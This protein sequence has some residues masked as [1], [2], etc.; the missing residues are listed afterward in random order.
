MTEIFMTQKEFIKLSEEWLACSLYV[1]Q[2]GSDLARVEA[3]LLE[4]EKQMANAPWEFDE[5]DQVVPCTAKG[6][7]TS[8]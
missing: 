4:I 7:P 1:S 3:R 2:D 6:G 5:N 8:C